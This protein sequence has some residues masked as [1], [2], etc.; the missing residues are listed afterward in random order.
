MGVAGRADEE[1]GDRVATPL[2]RDLLALSDSEQEV[3]VAGGSG[4]E[5]DVGAHATSESPYAACSVAIQSMVQSSIDGCHHVACAHELLKDAF[6]AY[7]T[8]A[9]IERFNLGKYEVLKG[10]AKGPQD[11]RHPSRAVLHKQ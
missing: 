10:G 11:V 4:S 8:D 9:A 1:E 6:V 7:G 2:R 3:A 5:S